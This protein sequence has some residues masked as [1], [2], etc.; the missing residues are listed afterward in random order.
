MDKAVVS[1]SGGQDSTTCLALVVQQLGAENVTAVSVRYG[2]KH[3]VELNAARKIARMVQV[4]HIEL[5]ACGLLA[6]VSPLVSASSIP[7]YRSEEQMKAEKVEPTF[8]PMRN[9][10]LITLLANQAVVHYCERDDAP[11]EVALVVGVSQEDY[12]GYPDCRDVFLESA[13]QAVRRSVTNRYNTRLQLHTPLLYRSKANTVRL[14]M[15]TPGAMHLLAHS[16]TCYHGCTPPN[17]FNHASILRA[18]GFRDAGAADPLITRLKKQQ[19][20]APDY[21][22]DGYVFGTRFAGMQYSDLLADAQRLK[23]E[24]KQQ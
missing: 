10:L 4:R 8:V 23:R 5:D 13:L 24:G 3:S 12:G 9:L 19:A 22:D 1:L 17:P 14:A 11:R 21:P 7:E 15:E 20:L 2:Q 6:S 16:H 18:R